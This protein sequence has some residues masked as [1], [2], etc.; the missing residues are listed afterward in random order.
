MSHQTED[1]ADALLDSIV[2]AVRLR[3]SESAD[4]TRP[5]A[6][7]SGEGLIV[8]LKATRWSLSAADATGII[9]GASVSLTAQVGE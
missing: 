7:A 1:G 4:S 3:L 2:K 8:E 6:L 9:R 5:I